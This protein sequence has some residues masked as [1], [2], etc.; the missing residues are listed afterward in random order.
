MNRRCAIGIL[1]S[2]LCSGQ[3]QQVVFVCPMDRDVR[4]LKPDKCPRCGMK[5]VAGIPEPQEYRVEL[6]LE[7]RAV[8]PGSPVRMTFRVIDPR[9]D[10][11]VRLFQLIHEKLFH[12]FLISEDL[13][14]FAH[15]HPE[16]QPDGAFHFTAALPRAGKYRLLCDF[17]PEGGTPQMIGKS[18]IVPGAAVLPTISAD[19]SPKKSENLSISLVSDPVQPLAGKKTMLFF[20]LNPSE[21]LEPYLGVWG[22]MLAASSDLI[23]LV[24][25]HP[26][27]EDRSPKVQFNI[28]F[29]RPGI[30][31]VWVQFQ[32]SGVVNT[33]A[34]NIPVA[35]L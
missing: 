2:A 35:P 27:W 25:S 22:H 10:T 7:P 31:R 8:R 4:S 5:L 12:L 34:F 20:E 23:D 24:H 29:P 6:K 3:S 21:G 17:Y 1:A 11:P 18:I 26:A 32:R 19:L 33:A 9:S 30:H 13:E 15:E 28:I 14:Y 16:P